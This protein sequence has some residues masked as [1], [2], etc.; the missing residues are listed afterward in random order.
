MMLENNEIMHLTIPGLVNRLVFLVLF[1]L[2]QAIVWI[3][4]AIIRKKKERK[5]NPA[6]SAAW[7]G[8]N[9]L[10]FTIC[11]LA[12]WFFIPVIPMLNLIPM[13]LVCI[14]LLSLA[15]TRYR[16]NKTP[17]TI[18][19]FGVY[20]ATIIVYAVLKGLFAGKIT[21]VKGILIVV[22]YITFFVAAL[23]LFHSEKTEGAQVAGKAVTEGT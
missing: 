9:A 4:L 8:V 11:E 10:L 19:R 3:V 2:V 14:V 5:K 12:M 6:V 15:W 20:A 16:R 17:Q 13:I 18:R 7:H 1:L 22:I 21:E 23:L